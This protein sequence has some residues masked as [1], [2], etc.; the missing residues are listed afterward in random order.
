MNFVESKIHLSLSLSQYIILTLKSEHTCIHEDKHNNQ[1][2]YD[3]HPW[4]HKHNENHK[5][6]QIIKITEPTSSSCRQATT[7]KELQKRIKP[8]LGT[9]FCHMPQ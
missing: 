6:L 5:P 9:M 1:S 3:K 7:S 8:P 2:L 4:N